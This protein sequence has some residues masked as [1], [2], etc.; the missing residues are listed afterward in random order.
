MN[1]EW[2]EAVVAL[3]SRNVAVGMTAR[4]LSSKQSQGKSSQ[5]SIG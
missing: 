4:T 3:A 2:I 5:S 1:V